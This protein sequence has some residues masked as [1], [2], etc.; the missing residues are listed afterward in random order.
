MGYLNTVERIET[1]L[2]EPG[3]QNTG[4]L[5]A[6]TET[7]V[8]V[9][10]ATGVGN[11][12]Y[13]AALT[14]PA[15]PDA[16]LVILRIAARLAVTIDSITAGTL[17]CRVYVD[18]QDANHRLFD[19]NWNVAGAK[20]AAQDTLT[21]TMQTIFN[22]LKNGAAHTFYFFFWVN[23]GNAVL[24]LVQ[25]WEG[26]GSCNLTP[27]Y[28]YL[29]INHIGWLTIGNRFSRVGTGTQSQRF[30]YDVLS[31]WR[32]FLTAAI[33]NNVQTHIVNPGMILTGGGSV[34]ADLNY[35]T[36]FKVVLRSER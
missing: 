13:S 23:A 1:L 18:Q 27:V 29:Q 35:L 33:E 28:A 34:A 4:D 12:D 15:P 9:A 7:I 8:A 22:L 5:E 14:L 6:A 36:D 30:V 11:A 25:L 21:G 3:L 2:Y 26:V 32:Q 20:L 31:K 19:L 10:E 24:S 16:R 17:N